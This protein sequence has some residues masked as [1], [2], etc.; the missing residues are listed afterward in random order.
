MK[1]KTLLSS[2]RMRPSL[3]LYF[4]AMSVMFSDVLKEKKIVRKINYTSL[5]MPVT[6][7]YYSNR[8]KN[9]PTI[10]FKLFSLIPLHVIFF[11]SNFAYGCESLYNFVWIITRASH[12]RNASLV[13]FYNVLVHQALFSSSLRPKF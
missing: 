13:L 4:V 7:F 3:I 12:G 6:I 11:G 8:E 1:K 10:I 5:L 2:V 9:I